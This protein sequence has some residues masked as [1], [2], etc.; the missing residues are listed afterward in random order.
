MKL[1]IATGNPGKFREIS[2]IL[3]DLPYELVSLADVQVEIPD[4]IE[5]GKTYEE[6]S[7]KK[8]SYA[9]KKSELMT[10]ADD[11]GIIV[12]H[13]QGQLGLKTRRWGAGEKVSDQEWLDYFLNRM[14]EAEDRSAVFVCSA[15]LVDAKGAL[16]Y[17]TIGETKGTLTRQ[18]LAQLKSGI[19]LSSCFI[20]ESYNKVYASFTDDEKAVISHRG[21]AFSKVRDYLMDQCPN[22][23]KI[24]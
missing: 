18:P 21:K 8:A 10:L 14:E 5:D 7:F 17:S 13:L 1:L 20:P 19:P 2:A 16:L 12:N 22:K 23:N 6:N 15:V 24:Q 4:A 11:S 3:K 9:A